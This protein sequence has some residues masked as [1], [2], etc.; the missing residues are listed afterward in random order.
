[1]PARPGRVDRTALVQAAMSRR[2]GGGSG[3]TQALAAAMQQF[4]TAFSSAMSKMV[5]QVGKAQEEQSQQSQQ[6]MA[7]IAN[8]AEQSYNQAQ[9]KAETEHQ[10]K[11]QDAAT[12][13][14]R[15][16]QLELADYQMALN[17]QVATDGKEI[18]LL[19]QQEE[20]AKN[21]ILEKRERSVATIADAR[22]SAW[23]W[24]NET[25]ADNGWDSLPNGLKTREQM[26]D[27]IRM[28]GVVNEDYQDSP[29][30]D[31]LH[32][33]VGEA[34]QAILVGGTE[35]ESVVGTQ[36]SPP[37][38]PVPTSMVKSLGLDLPMLTREEM[39][40]W[41]NRNGYPKGGVWAM[42][43][44]D[45]K[46]LMVNPVGFSALMAA[47]QQDTF[48]AMTGAKMS[49]RDFLLKQAKK[50][51]EW[52]EYAGPIEE[53]A[54]ELTKQFNL[55]VPDALSSVL[56]PIAKQAGSIPGVGVAET[57]VGYDSRS[58]LQ[59]I[60]A[61]V[62]R[63]KPDL[64]E[65]AMRLGLPEGDP[66]RWVPGADP[67]PAKKAQ[68]FY[69]VQQIKAV[70]DA[71]ANHLE[72]GHTDPTFR[73][74]VAAWLGGMSESQV[75][76]A[77]LS[78][79]VAGAISGIKRGGVAAERTF[80][81]VPAR[82]LMD[83]AVSQVIANLSIANREQIRIPARNNT[84]MHVW[85]ESN[86]AAAVLQDGTAVAVLSRMDPDE[87]KSAAE[88]GSLPEGL[89]EAAANPGLFR[90][91]V[92]ILKG[93]A[94][95]NSHPGARTSIQT[96]IQGGVPEEEAEIYDNEKYNQVTA[97]YQHVAENGFGFTS[98]SA[99]PGFP[100]PARK[101]QPYRSLT[102]L[103]HKDRAAAVSPPG[104]Q[105]PGAPAQPPT[106]PT[107][108]PRPGQGVPPAASPAV[109]GF[110][111]P[112]PNLGEASQ[113]TPPAAPKPTPAQAPQPSPSPLSPPGLEG[114]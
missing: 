49:Q 80:G 33:M 112:Q 79:D 45:P 68:D 92:G 55:M 35:F 28:S 103:L 66:K 104:E 85:R 52:D 64:A 16:Y 72:T 81:V 9:R 91:P 37:M 100:A 29:Y 48:L 71:L 22:E 82:K 1:M 61:S 34:Q 89:T 13:G 84:V 50:Q 38:L 46:L 65:K 11:R 62:L 93:V 83:R 75:W 95:M 42:K 32:A 78:D 36:P 69:D 41:E 56:N 17:K 6:A 106:P 98:V 25:D 39:E 10:E 86:H 70:T 14:A 31:R 30:S 53:A 21:R 59:N 51:R 15:E 3:G 113:L 20:A 54:V 107:P 102:D 90:V 7:N 58:L 18:A 12:E 105:A 60:Y 44:D 24:I 97:Y 4:M 43:T 40:E 73:S 8:V 96:Y 47:K 101:A 57:P 88:S 67:D 87:L 109:G 23:K 26:L 27:L 77:G 114:Q 5:Q 76:Q 19:M 110:G 94:M 99:K 63:G 2:G 111:E 108:Q 74:N